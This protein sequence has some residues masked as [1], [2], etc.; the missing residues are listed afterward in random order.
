MLQSLYCALPWYVTVR[1]RS[2]GM[3]GIGH[4]KNAAQLDRCLTIKIDV[5]FPVQSGVRRHTG[6]SAQRRQ[7]TS[8]IAHV[9]GRIIQSCVHQG[10]LCLQQGRHDGVWVHP[11]AM[12]HT[13]IGQIPGSIQNLDVLVLQ[14]GSQRRFQPYVCNRITSWCWSTLHTVSTAEARPAVQPARGH[15]GFCHVA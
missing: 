6:P 1:Y 7:D 15:K 13:C 8:H 4:Y 5:S 10:C 2:P 3:L 11:W 9:L 12:M 14:P